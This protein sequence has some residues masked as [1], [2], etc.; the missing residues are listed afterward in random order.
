MVSFAQNEPVRREAGP[1]TVSYSIT[2]SAP[3]DEI[4]ALVADPHRHHEIDGS[5]TVQSRAMGPHELTEGARFT[6]HM[7]K[8][9]LPYH[10]PLRVTRARRPAPGSPG[11]IEWRQPTGHRWRWEFECLEDNDA[12]TPRTLVTESFDTAQQ[13]PPARAVLKLA[14]VFAANAESIRESLRRVQR[15]FA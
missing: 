8:Y 7:R 14:R 2:V 10:L 1:D 9:R 5:E 4:Y 3:A 13:F 6:V 12:A 11:V 15:R